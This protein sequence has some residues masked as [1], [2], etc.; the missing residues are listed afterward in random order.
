MRTNGML[1]MLQND[2]IA[3]QWKEKSYYNEKGITVGF[4]GYIKV[5]ELIFREKNRDTKEKGCTIGQN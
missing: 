4:V 1:L 2:Q 3:Q 5:I